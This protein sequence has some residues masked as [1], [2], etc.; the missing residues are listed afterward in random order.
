MLFASINSFFS[1]GIPLFPP[2]VEGFTCLGQ[3]NT[4]HTRTH[5]ISCSHH[6]SGTMPTQAPHPEL[7]FRPCTHSLRPFPIPFI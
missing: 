6:T 2:A 3:S 5:S 1:I 4:H 7:P